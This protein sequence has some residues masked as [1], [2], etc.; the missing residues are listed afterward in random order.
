LENYIEALRPASDADGAMAFFSRPLNSWVL[1]ARG[2]SSLSFRTCS[3]TCQNTLRHV[4]FPL[5]FPLMFFADGI[6]SQ[7]R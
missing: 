1:A 5:T 3:D 7:H 4:E 6:R 2:R